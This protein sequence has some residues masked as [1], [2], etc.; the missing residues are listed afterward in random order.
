VNQTIPQWPI[1]A[2]LGIFVFLLSVFLPANASTGDK[3]LNSENMTG[4]GNVES[5]AMQLKHG[6]MYYDVKC[7]NGFVL[8]LK[9]TDNSPACVKPSTVET[10]VERGWAKG[11]TMMKMTGDNTMQ[12]NTSMNSS[13]I[14]NK[15][16]MQDNM[17]TEEAPVMSQPTIN[18]SM[19]PSAPALVGITGYINTTPS[20]LAEDMKGKIIV[21]DFWTFDCINCIHTLPHVVDLSNKYLGKDVL[22]IGIHSPETFFEKD[23]NNVQNA[24]SRYNIQYPVVI[25]NDFQTW[26]AFGN[27]YWPH[28]YIADAQG[29]IRYD[30]IGEGAYDEID[31]TV[32]SLLLEKEN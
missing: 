8:V 16:M 18:E 29:K 4:M 9:S 19:Y 22:V 21:Y 1:F 11:N 27:H 25:D 7:N 15:T 3:M 6:V 30:H 5:P 24:V 13:S 12:N 10:L 26:N 2:V 23:L 31:N 14:M 32:A 20:K 17:T 28:V